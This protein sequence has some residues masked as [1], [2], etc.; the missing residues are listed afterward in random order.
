MLSNLRIRVSAVIIKDKQILFIKR[1]KSRVV[2]YVFPGG[3]VEAGETKER[4]LAREVIEELGLE[5]KGYI[6]LFMIKQEGQD[7]Y[8]YQV[9][10]TDGEPIIGGPEKQRMNQDNI[11]QLVWVKFTEL[12]KVTD[13]YNKEVIVKIRNI[14]KTGI[15]RTAGGF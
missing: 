1:V 9:D 7:N 11:Y 5:V 8:F 10:V 13:S 15:F 4:A 14:I 6:F 3:G 2:Y 12:A